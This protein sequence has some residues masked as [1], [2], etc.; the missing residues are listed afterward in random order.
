MTAL[1]VRAPGLSK[2]GGQTAGLDGRSP[3][4]EQSP[5]FGAHGD[6]RP[7]HGVARAAGEGGLAGGP[8]SGAS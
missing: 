5:G 8:V 2:P 4:R 7:H 6:I 3:L 1:S